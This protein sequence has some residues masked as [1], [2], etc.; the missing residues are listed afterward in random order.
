MCT[1]APTPCGAKDV[2]A[3]KKRDQVVESNYQV[4]AICEVE[5]IDSHAQGEALAI[6]YQSFLLTHGRALPTRPLSI[7]AKSVRKA[8]GVTFA[9]VAR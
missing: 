1:S 7:S 5:R 3:P 9:F 4:D 8:R 2:D 6:A